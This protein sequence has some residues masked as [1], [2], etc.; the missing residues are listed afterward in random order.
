[1]VFPT[2]EQFHKGLKYV[3]YK[4]TK[5]S[6]SLKNSHFLQHCST[7]NHIDSPVLECVSSTR[8]ASVAQRSRS[9]LR[10]QDKNQKYMYV[11][12][13]FIPDHKN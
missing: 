5:I 4:D 11:K 10:I 2:K 9:H 8:L 7:F 12:A 13:C 1:M 3:L 6:K